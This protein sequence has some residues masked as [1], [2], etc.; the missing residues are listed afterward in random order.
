MDKKSRLRVGIVG[1]GTVAKR[2]ADALHN[3][4]GF[5][6]VAVAE[7]SDPH[8]DFTEQGQGFAKR[9][10]CHFVSSW[11]ELVNRDDIE[12]IIIATVNQLHL[13]IGMAA[14]QHG[15]HV[16]IEKP[17]ARSVQE[18]QQLLAAA[19]HHQRLIKTG[20]NHRHHPWVQ[21]VYDWIREGR[22]GKPLWS[23]AFIGHAGMLGGGR[24]DF[25]GTWF[26]DQE[27]AG[28]GTLLDNGVHTHDLV[29]WLLGVDFME[30]L[31]WAVAVT[32]TQVEDNAG[33]VFKTADERLYVFQSTWTTW[34]NYLTLEVAGTEG[35]LLIDYGSGTATYIRPVGGRERTRK[36]VFFDIKAPDQ[37]W[38]LELEVF[39]K[40]ICEDREP[41]G[42]GQ[43]GLEALA[44]SE[45]LYR[46]SRTGRAVRLE[47]VY[48]DLQ[49][50]PK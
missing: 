15:K 34:G 1:S 3:L 20:F 4:E 8:N 27:K 17:L 46:S 32:D 45:A 37:S 41:I 30:A 6:L 7:I 22:L 11:D 5:G 23:R 33:G 13:P 35:N 29:R 44:M 19:K 47:D 40:A 26:A 43:D 31:G 18:A 2:R 49:Q 38:A 42:N 16:L 28:G 21:K 39:R 50:I 48:P 25:G 14:L 12:I 36:T 10:N 24:P 9:Y